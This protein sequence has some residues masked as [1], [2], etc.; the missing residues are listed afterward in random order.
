VKGIGAGSIPTEAERIS[1]RNFH[2]FQPISK[3]GRQRL[4]IGKPLRLTLIEGQTFSN[5]TWKTR[6][7]DRLGIST[8]VVRETL[9]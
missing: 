4:N 6:V 9:P 3:Q 8:E 1:E 5:L 7:I 2:P